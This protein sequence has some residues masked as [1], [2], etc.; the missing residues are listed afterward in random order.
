MIEHRTVAPILNAE[1]PPDTFGVFWTKTEG[2]LKRQLTTSLKDTIMTELKFLTCT[3]Q[4]LDNEDEIL[5]V[6]RV[7]L[8]F[9]TI[10]GFMQTLPRLAPSS[11]TCIYKGK[12]F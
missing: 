7:Q 6:N 8:G 10:K 2:Y 3:T 11:S 4:A 12:Y 9:T 5:C 1:S